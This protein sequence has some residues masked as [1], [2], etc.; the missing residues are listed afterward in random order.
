LEPEAELLCNSVSSSVLD[1]RGKRVVL[2]LQEVT[3]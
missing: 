3:I 2:N 1:I